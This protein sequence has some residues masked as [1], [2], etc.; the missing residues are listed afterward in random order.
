MV[1]GQLQS[2]E[3]MRINTAAEQTNSRRKHNYKKGENSD[4]SLTKC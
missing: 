1:N 2:Y 3:L 4:Q